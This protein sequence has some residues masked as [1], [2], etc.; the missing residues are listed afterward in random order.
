MVVDDGTLCRFVDVTVLVDVV[1]VT[2]TH[3]IVAFEVLFPDLVLY[4]HEGLGV[5]GD[6]DQ[7][8]FLVDANRGHDGIVYRE[9]RSPFV[10]QFIKETRDSVSGKKHF[11]FPD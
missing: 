10:L 4:G 8:A 2:L 11:A 7:L 5:T 3:Q 1:L 6:A 9:F